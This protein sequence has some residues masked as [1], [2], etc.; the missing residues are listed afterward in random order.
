L[1]EPV[2]ATFLAAVILR[3]AITFGQWIGIVLVI[4]GLALVDRK[5]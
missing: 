2:T 3:E 5:N 4:A 1:I